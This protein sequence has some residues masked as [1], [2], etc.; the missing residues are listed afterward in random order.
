MVDLAWDVI[1]VGAGAAGMMAAE[2]AARRG[3][4]TLILEKNRKPGVKILMSGG[5]RCNL[6]QATD[7][8]GIIETFGAQGRFLKHAVWE[9]SPEQV[10]RYFAL[11][12][13][14]TKV[15]STG[16]IFPVRDRAL[17]VQQAMWRQTL[18][19]GAT[20]LLGQSV[21]S[22]EREAS[23]W[24]VRTSDA[25]F[26]SQSLIVTT[27]GCSYPGCGTTGD[28]YQWMEGLGHR[29]VTPHPAL[30][31]LIHET[32]WLRQLSGVTLE[33][34]ELNVVEATR[35]ASVQ[36]LTERMAIVR[37]R[38]LQQRRGSLLL[39]HFGFSGP[40]AMDVSR[41]F[42][43]VDD[44]RSRLLVCDFLPD[45]SWEELDRQL[46]DDAARQ[47]GRTLVRVL[48]TRLPQR[49]LQQLLQHAGMDPLQRLAELNKT[50]R[51]Q[52]VSE[53]KSF[54][55]P[56]YGSRGFAKAE[57]TA[58]GVHRS[59]VDPHSMASKRASGLFVAGEL[60]DVDGPIGGFNFQAA[61]STG[62]LAGGVA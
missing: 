60:L 29:I 11:A 53:L 18:D 59:D 52:L 62:R 43:S 17:D 30:V 38:S 42:T 56:I 36:D 34:V 24:L 49:L 45:V 61:F 1:V 22:V 32:E 44:P 14:P 31:P 23:G 57:V 40:V 4:R 12:G 28:A 5:T 54:V 27:G 20:P 55:V 2:T 26:R 6:T 9:F 48:E 35:L 3:R 19:A 58:G 51:R 10:V 47:G 37:K 7:T 8:D 15:E 25:D 50:R 41:Q 16:K 21:T 13:V 39:T 46:T 33:Q